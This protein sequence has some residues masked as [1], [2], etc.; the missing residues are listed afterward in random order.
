M[1]AS[2]T[3]ANAAANGA[4]FASPRFSKTTVPAVSVYPDAD[5]V[6]VWPDDETEFYFKRS[7]AISRAEALD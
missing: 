6:G 5:A 2:G 7:A 4:L 3:V 1:I